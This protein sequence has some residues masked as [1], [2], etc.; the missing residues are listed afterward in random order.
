M[1][2]NRSWM[3]RGVAAVIVSNKIG[4]G[5]ALRADQQRRRAAELR[6]RG[7]AKGEPLRERR[8]R[9]VDAAEQFARL[10]HVGVVAGD[11]IDRGPRVRARSRGHRV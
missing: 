4:A 2:V 8:C 9:Q 10:Q 7:V 6:E 5:R 1:C 11:E 3:G